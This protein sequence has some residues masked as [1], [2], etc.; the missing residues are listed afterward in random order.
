M[1]SATVAAI[2]VPIVLFLVVGLLLLGLLWYYR[3]HKI[4]SRLHKAPTGLQRLADHLDDRNNYRGNLSDVSSSPYANGYDRFN[5]AVNLPPK[6]EGGL[7]LNPAYV[8][9][10]IQEAVETGEADEFEF[11]FHRLELKRVLGKGAFGKV[12]LA[13]AY[14]MGDTDQDTSLVAVKVLNDKAN[15]DEV[16]DFKMEIN[17]MKTIGLHEN[18][19]TMLGCCTLYPPLCLVVEYVPHGDLL[20][21]LRDLRK[22]VMTRHSFP[23]EPYSSRARRRK[24]MCGCCKAC[25]T[26]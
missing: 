15:E 4:P 10:R 21:Y 25:C 19:V 14:G 20:H 17:F 12:F 5:L 11:G 23:R 24:I 22:A 18:V 8:E 7:E 26:L 9:Q 1:S 16:E 3:K 2:T 6:S 13:E